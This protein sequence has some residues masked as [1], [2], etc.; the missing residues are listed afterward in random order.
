MQVTLRGATLR[1][2]ASRALYSASKRVFDV[3]G[4]LVL[5]IVLSPLLLAIGIAI[6]IDSGVP[7]LY[8]CHRLGRDGRPITIFKFRTMHDGTHHHLEELLSVDEERRLEYALNRKLRR[9]PRRTRLGVFLRRAS[10]DELPQLL[11]VLAGDMSMV[12]PRPYMPDELD[13]RN[14]AAE[15]LSV[16]PG[17]TGLWQVNGRSDRTFEERLEIEVSYVRRRGFRL[18]LSILRQTVRAVLTG[19]GAY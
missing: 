12:G 18:D 19:R 14:E 3:V 9:D 15:L 7:L 13:A 8:R 11:N 5:L 1:A 10:L 6:Y 2:P 16:R 4:S 17:I